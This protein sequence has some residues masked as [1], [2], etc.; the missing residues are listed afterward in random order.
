MLLNHRI[1]EHCHQNDLLNR[2]QIGFKPNHRTADHL[3]TLKAVVKKYV[4]IGGK[5]LFACFI[6]FKKAF[7]SV[8]HDGLFHKLANYGIIN[9]CL[10]LI[11]DIYKKTECSVKVGNESTNT[12][13]FSKGVRQGCPMSPYL[14]N[15]FVDEIFDIV[16][17]GNEKNI[18]L[19]EG[20]FIN[21]LMY[22]DDL[23][24]LSET[25]YGL[26]K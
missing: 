8:W 23:I 18:F 15:L 3:L 5:K 10:S 24:V 1:Q 14:F 12:F 26:Q 17:Q 13:K 4:T 20:K 19:V 7:D 16:N 25:E 22:A 9:N 11:M 6:D 2:N 21:A